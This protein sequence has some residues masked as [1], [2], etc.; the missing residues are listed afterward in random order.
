MK[1]PPRDPAAR[2]RRKQDLLM[3]SQVLRGQADFALNTLG[4]R[5]D[6]V[7]GRYRRVRDFVRQPAVLYG[8]G[9]LATLWLLKPRKRRAVRAAAGA[10][11]ARRAGGSRLLRLALLGWRLWGIAGPMFFPNAAPRRRR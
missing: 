11:A 9:S 2:E 1:P 6:V 8:V 5:A 7:V 4:E 10:T 3:A